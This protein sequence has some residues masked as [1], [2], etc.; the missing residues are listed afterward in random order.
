MSERLT[1]RYAELRHLSHKVGYSSVTCNSVTRF[2]D[3]TTDFAG[4]ALPCDRSPGGEF[5]LQPPGPRPAGF[6]GRPGAAAPG[7]ANSPVLTGPGVRLTCLTASGR[8]PTL[9]FTVGGRP[10]TPPAC[11]SGAKARL[12]GSTASGRLPTPRLTVREPHHPRTHARLRH[13]L[14][15]T[16]RDHCCLNRILK[17]VDRCTR[18]GV[19]NDPPSRG[20]EGGG[21]ICRECSAEGPRVGWVHGRVFGEGR[22]WRSWSVTRALAVRLC[23]GASPEI[24][25]SPGRGNLS[26]RSSDAAAS[27]A[28]DEGPRP[29]PAHRYRSAGS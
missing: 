26:G 7:P 22:E 17:M 21:P 8:L 14:P 4:D 6:P 15:C 25:S 16:Y 2:A 12:T 9:R 24:G 20:P 23:P 5:P 28:A 3:T 11:A 18:C 19:Y 10:P 13:N 27:S 29:R 1:A